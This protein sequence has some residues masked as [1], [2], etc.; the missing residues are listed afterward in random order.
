LFLSGR[1]QDGLNVGSELLETVET[2]PL[3]V[4][5]AMDLVSGP[6]ELLYP[7][8]AEAQRIWNY[9]F[10]ALEAGISFA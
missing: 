9:P 10:S 3:E 4:Y 7:K 1:L 6:D 5:K 2:S 8:N